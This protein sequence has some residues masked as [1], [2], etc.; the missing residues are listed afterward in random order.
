M[1]VQRW[2]GGIVWCGAVWCDVMVWCGVM[3]CDVLWCGVVWWAANVI[4]LLRHIENNLNSEL[5]VF[6]ANFTLLHFT[7]NFIP[8][9]C[10]SSCYCC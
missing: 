1:E 5:F 8:G 4:I 7:S 10:C 9:Y 6:H 2:K 3:R